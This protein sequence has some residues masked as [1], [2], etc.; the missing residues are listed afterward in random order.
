[1]GNPCNAAVTASIAAGI[2]ARIRLQNK[3][4]SAGICG[5]VA[6]AVSAGY[7]EITLR[8]INYMFCLAWLCGSLFAKM[9]HGMC[10]VCLS[11]RNYS[12]TLL[13]GYEIKYC[14]FHGGYGIL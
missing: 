5:A 14:Y 2:A 12:I 6:K 4:K 1:M 13:S 9:L 10:F 8:Y 7:I 3:S 11:C